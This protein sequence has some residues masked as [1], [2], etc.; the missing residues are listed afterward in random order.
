MAYVFPTVADFK[1]YF[2][3]NFPFSTPATGS[4]GDATDKTKVMD[5]D[6]TRAFMKAQFGFNA[7]L[8]DTQGEFTV[9]ALLLSAHYLLL[10]ARASNQGLMGSWAWSTQQT[11]IGG[12]QTTYGIPKRVQDSPV[13][14]ALSKTPYG[15]E[16]LAFMI[17]RI[18]G[19]SMVVY[20]QTLP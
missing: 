16:Y 17:P 18:T 3:R 2:A 9:G 4:G 6:I 15:A 12:V 1:V 7:D 5:S 13:F 10:D 8:F 20:G 19:V 11:S 14:S